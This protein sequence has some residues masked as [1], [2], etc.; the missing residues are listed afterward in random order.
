MRRLDV[1]ERQRP[2]LAEKGEDLEPQQA[3][4]QDLT[5][6]V[7]SILDPNFMLAHVE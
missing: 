5:Y 3:A 4:Y 2:S 6:D 7:S 1:Q